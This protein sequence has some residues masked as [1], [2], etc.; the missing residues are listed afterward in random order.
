MSF[1]LSGLVLGIMA[2]DITDLMLLKKA[3]TPTQKRHAAQL[4]PIR[5]NGNRIL[6]TLLLANVAAN[7]L[8][9]VFMNNLISGWQTFIVSTLTL[10]I[11]GEIIPQAVFNRH[12]FILAAKS[13]LF[14]K[15]LLYIT[16]PFAFPIGMILDRI[17][18]DE[19]GMSYTRMQMKQLIE[20]QNE[21]GKL[22]WFYL[23][24]L[25]FL[26]NLV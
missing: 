1:Y 11:I 9:T 5:K 26:L 15:F 13:I 7:S 20:L 24:I 18:G 6:C 25:P 2:I 4:L 21:T 23:S 10:C 8:V 22:V 17:L 14:I 12:G 19:A 16:A 3:G